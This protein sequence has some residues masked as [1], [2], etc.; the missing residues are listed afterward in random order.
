MAKVLQRTRS[1]PQL[2][3]AESSSFLEVLRERKELGEN[4]MGNLC[5]ALYRSGDQINP[6]WYQVGAW[7]SA[8]EICQCHIGTTK[9][10]N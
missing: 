10:W 5:K 9:N 3:H 7:W 8:S 2:L 6:T 1:I 4:Q